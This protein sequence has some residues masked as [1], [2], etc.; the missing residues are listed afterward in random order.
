MPCKSLFGPARVKVREPLKEVDLVGG[1]TL[2]HMRF[3]ALRFVEPGKY[4]DLAVY[5]PS[6]LH[7]QISLSASRL[8]SSAQSGARVRGTVQFHECQALH[9]CP[10]PT[11][12]LSD[13]TEA[14]QNAGYHGLIAPVSN[15]SSQ[16]FVVSPL[17]S[18]MVEA[19]KKPRSS[20]MNWRSK[21]LQAWFS[22]V[23]RSQILR[24]RSANQCTPGPVCQGRRGHLAD[25]CGASSHGSFCHC[26]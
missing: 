25:K 24:R 26:L 19:K 23:R 16:N 21:P 20:A 9:E 4:S 3:Q 7:F 12:S 10:A 18:I 1:P 15:Q 6:M 2:Y 5:Y 17:P 11:C 13:H 22:S 14:L 8:A